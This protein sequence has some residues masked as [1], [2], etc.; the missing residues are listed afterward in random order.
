MQTM[1]LRVHTASMHE[2]LKKTAN[3]TTSSGTHSRYRASQVPVRIAKAS[4]VPTTKSSAWAVTNA[5]TPT[6]LPASRLQRGTGLASSTDTDAGSRN[7]GRNAAVH[8]SVS[9]SPSVPATK[10]A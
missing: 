7:V 9:S 2:K 1:V 8:T 5:S 6:Y 10:S 4:H 3:W